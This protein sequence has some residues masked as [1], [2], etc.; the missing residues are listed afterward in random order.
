MPVRIPKAA[1]IRE[2]TVAKCSESV[3][4][5]RR[6]RLLIYEVWYREKPEPDLVV[7]ILMPRRR[8]AGLFRELK[9]ICRS[10]R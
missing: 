8:R 3:M 1:Y 4:L 6:G 10:S 7:S 9:D 5:K 2:P